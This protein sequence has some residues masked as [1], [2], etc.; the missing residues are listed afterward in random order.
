MATRDPEVT[1][2]IMSQIRSSGGKAETLLGKHMWALGLRYRKQYPIK[3][4]PDFAFVSAKVAVFCDGD[5]WHG[6]DFDERVKAGRFKTN[7][8]YWLKKIPRNVERDTET[9]NVLRG[10]GW[11]VIRFWESDI[12][13]NPEKIASK[14]EAQVLARKK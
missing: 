11:K 9:N 12:L 3:G 7:Q 13:A 2:R 8:D 5:F 4:K 14:V 10:L 1:S 6:R